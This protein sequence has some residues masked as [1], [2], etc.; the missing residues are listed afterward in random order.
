MIT[1]GYIRDLI[2]TNF[3]VYGLYTYP[4]PSTGDQGELQLRSVLPIPVRARLS[5]F[6]LT[7]LHD[8]QIQVNSRL[9]SDP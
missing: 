5:L 9:C 3:M 4:K 2:T 7:V 1:P 6:V 8:N